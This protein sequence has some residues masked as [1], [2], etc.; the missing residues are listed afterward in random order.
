MRGPNCARDADAR[1][2][3]SV[4]IVRFRLATE[5]LLTMILHGTVFDL[6][7]AGSPAQP[8]Q[9]TRAGTTRV[10]PLERWRRGGRWPASYDQYWQALMERHGRQHG[11]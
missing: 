8:V 4:A 11:T 6:K 10:A 7:H 5:D 3:L 9:K 2:Q 1:H